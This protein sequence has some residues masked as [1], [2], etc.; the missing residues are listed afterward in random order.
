MEIVIVFNM[1]KPYRKLSSWMWKI[2]CADGD[3]NS[4]G[5]VDGKSKNDSQTVPG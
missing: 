5:N 3:E 2:G 4:D 1:Y